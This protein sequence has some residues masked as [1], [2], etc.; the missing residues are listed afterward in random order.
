MVITG[1]V[2]LLLLLGLVPVVPARVGT[3]WLW[4]ARRRRLLVA[5]VLLAPSPPQDLARRRTPVGTVRMATPSHCCSSTTVGR[6]D[7]R[8]AARPWQPTA[9]ATDNRH[10]SPSPR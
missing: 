5:D 10:R 9:G 1:R 6:A 8:A 2:P 3:V 4:V 7:A